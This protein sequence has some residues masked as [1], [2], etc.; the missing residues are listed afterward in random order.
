MRLSPAP[1]A[2]AR[3]S[4]LL[5]NQSGVE[6]ALSRAAAALLCPR[7]VAC[8][9][10]DPD[11]VSLAGEAIGGCY[12]Y[13]LPVAVGATE[14]EGGGSEGGRRGERGNGSAFSL[15]AKEL[16][17]P[18]FL[19]RERG[20]RI[21]GKARETGVELELEK[22]G[23]SRFGVVGARTVA[24]AGFGGR[25]QDDVVSRGSRAFDGADGVQD[26]GRGEEEERERATMANGNRRERGQ[27]VWE[28]PRGV[29]LS[30]RTPLAF[31]QRTGSATAG[32]T[33][34][35]EQK[36]TG[37]TVGGGRSDGTP[38][39]ERGFCGGVAVLG[40]GRQRKRERGKTVWETPR[41]VGLTPT[42]PRATPT[43]G[44]RKALRI[45]GDEAPRQDEEDEEG[46][47]FVPG[48]S[49]CNSYSSRSRNISSASC[50][51]QRLRARGQTLWETPRGVG[52][53]P[54]TPAAGW[55]RETQQVLANGDRYGDDGDGD[56]HPHPEGEEGCFLLGGSVFRHGQRPRAR[57]QTVWETPRGVGLTPKTPCAG[58][59]TAGPRFSADCRVGEQEGCGHPQREH[60]GYMSTS[61]SRCGLRPRARGQT[62]W[63]T[64]RGV[65]L[66][67]RTPDAA[68]GRSRFS[69]DATFG[70]DG[71]HGA[72]R[73]YEQQRH[74]QQ[75]QQEEGKE[76]RARLPRGGVSHAGQR[77]RARGQTV[78]ET[79]RGVGLTPTPKTPTGG[80]ASC[81]DQRPRARGQTVWETPRGVGLTPKTPTGEGRDRGEGGEFYAPEGYS[82]GDDGGNCGGYGD[83]A[84][85]AERMSRDR[86]SLAERRWA[87]GS[88]SGYPEV[89]SF[90]QGH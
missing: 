40:E 56:D 45:L 77:P 64:P 14:R 37:T 51:G 60:G 67:P 21:S 42:Q 26:E 27:T 90:A 15:L 83:V 28:T 48:G 17:S 20:E 46:G 72:G 47:G 38:T 58:A 53:T 55:W 29:G 34:E 71:D 1:R 84:A 19:T 13:G 10:S 5:D 65:G 7:T 9:S 18:A 6:G 79:P 61:V 63:E 30:P 12:E 43:P 82:G 41:G 66:T 31:Y 25:K 88:G 52:L 44:S 23:S 69:S 8:L 39:P 70:S 11:L 35:K 75:Q 24:S 87:A 32:A 22:G 73:G 78:W 33:S 74:Q 80:S 62:V 50:G 2:Q 4:W 59:G 86:G 16:F 81:G 3:L 49:C 68:G 57:G 36:K 89:R 54:K 85:S 76:E